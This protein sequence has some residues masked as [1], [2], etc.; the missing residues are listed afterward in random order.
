MGY[1]D[2]DRY[3]DPKYPWALGDLQEHYWEKFPKKLLPPDNEEMDRILREQRE[4]LQ[5][6]LRE[7]QGFLEQQLP[8]DD[9]LDSEKIKVLEGRIEALTED[10]ERLELEL[11]NLD[12]YNMVALEATIKA[13]HAIEGESTFST[14]NLLVAVGYLTALK[15][16]ED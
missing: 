5:E 12:T 14:D 6:M 2:Y 1:Y 16:P 7:K 8:E 11:R 3:Y 9:E 10:K 4:T 13:I 15:D